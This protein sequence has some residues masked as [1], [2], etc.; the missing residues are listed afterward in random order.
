MTDKETKY[1]LRLE[2][3]GLDIPIDKTATNYRCCPNCSIGFMAD[4]QKQLYCCQKCHD[5]FNNAKLKEKTKEMK[6]ALA[7]TQNEFQEISVPFKGTKF[8][9][10][11]YSKNF[12]KRLFKEGVKEVECEVNYLTN[13]GVN[14]DVF[15]R[16]I[17]L[18]PFLD[19]IPRYVTRIGAF[20]IERL[21][22][23]SVL[24]KNY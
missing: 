11:V 2:K 23:D 8:K 6:A 17:P 16:K 10:L 18:K 12:L 19:N 3:R 15:H 24:I 20:T 22:N 13:N 9:Q 14:L 21:T 7:A 5:D 4:D 1:K